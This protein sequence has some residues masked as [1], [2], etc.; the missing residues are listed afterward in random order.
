MGLKGESILP[1]LCA[2]QHFRERFI[3]VLREIKVGKFDKHSSLSG[4][5][6]SYVN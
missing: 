4:E 2:D 5:P 6:L 3:K 1:W